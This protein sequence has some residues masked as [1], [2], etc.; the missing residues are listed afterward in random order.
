MFREVS[1]GNEL[2]SIMAWL[3]SGLMARSENFDFSAEM[4][5]SARL[6]TFPSW[7]IR[8][9][10]ISMP[11]ILLI[12]GISIYCAGLRMPSGILLKISR[13]PMLPV[14]IF[15]RSF[16]LAVLHASLFIYPRPVAFLISSEGDAQFSQK[17]RH[18]LFH[19][20]GAHC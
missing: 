17:A 2:T 15:P 19:A 6:A 20:H 16:L 8:K 14:I 11:I 4:R 9:N 3:H 18:P 1:R 7:S 12:E 5:S 10:S 13:S